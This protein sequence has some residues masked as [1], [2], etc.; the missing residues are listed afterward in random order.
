MKLRQITLFNCQQKRYSAIRLY[1]NPWDENLCRYT[2]MS[3][4]SKRGSKPLLKKRLFCM[5][6]FPCLAFDTS[7]TALRNSVFGSYVY[8]KINLFQ[9]K[10]LRNLKKIYKLISIQ[11]DF[12][13]R[14]QCIT[15]NHLVGF[16][17]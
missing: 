9:V 3:K 6:Y 11:P 17:S 5:S 13:A 2:K 4:N 8:F 16:N 12:H 10:R 14:I 1:Q 15:N 7:M